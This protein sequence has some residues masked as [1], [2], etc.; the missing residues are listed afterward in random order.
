MAE[1][2]PIDLGRFAARASHLRPVIASGKIVDIVGLTLQA[3]GP[4]MRIGDVCHVHG[5]D[6]RGPV[7]VEVV[8]FRGDRILLMPLGDMTGIGPGNWVVPTHRP[9]SLRVGHGLLGRVL[10]G[11]GHPIDDQPAPRWDEEV[12]LLAA[13]PPYTDFTAAELD[14]RLG[15]PQLIRLPDGRL[16]A[17]GRIHPEQGSRTALLWLDPPSKQL[18]EFL[19]L[20]SGGDN[21]YP[22]LVSDD[23]E[24]LVI[25]YSSHEGKSAIYFTRI[26]LPRP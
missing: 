10:D 19:V 23:G 16:L 2:G 26:R 17:A 25:Y 12:P 15:G 11:L 20:P 18:R 22:G 13:P 4:A 5:N 8:G 14:R 3:T 9:R 1:R 7:P 21:S 6:A 24:I